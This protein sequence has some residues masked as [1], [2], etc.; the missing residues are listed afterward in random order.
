MT[1]HLHESIFARFWLQGELPD[2][3]WLGEVIE[4]VIYGTLKNRPGFKVSTALPVGQSVIQLRDRPV[5]SRPL[6]GSIERRWQTL[7]TGAGCRRELHR[8]R[9]VLDLRYIGVAT[10]R[11]PAWTSQ[12][13]FRYRS[14]QT[15]AR[16][17]PRAGRRY[18]ATSYS[19][20]PCRD[21][22]S[23][24]RGD[25]ADVSP[26]VRQN[27]EDFGRPCWQSD[28]S[29]QPLWECGSFRAVVRPRRDTPTGSMCPLRRKLL[30]MKESDAL[31]RV[32]KSGLAQLVSSIDVSAMDV[33]EET[34]R[35]VREL[36]R[37][38]ALDAA[39]AKLRAAQRIPVVA[40]V[41]QQ[42]PE[43]AADSQ[44]RKAVNE[45]TTKFFR[46]HLFDC[47]DEDGD[48]V[49]VV[50]NGEPFSTIPITHEGSLVSVPLAPGANAISLRGIRDGG[51]GITVSFRTS[52]GDYFCGRM[53]VG[54]ERQLGVV[55]P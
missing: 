22:A 27:Q 41:Q 49:Q 2:D 12:K 55:I 46:L 44:L 20:S 25:P 21:T 23:A 54:Q 15:T 39:T 24:D 26:A 50:V 29:R 51:G 28:C 4:A 36:V 6:R 8:G 11:I 35:S 42:E 47:C 10:K 37:Q 43:I 34:T 1:G 17:P 16:P 32:D 31:V 3:Y 7:D 45:E 14:R 33:D 13:C 18:R 40:D 48:I 5:A 38:D 9:A 52:Q 30:S 53:R 19:A